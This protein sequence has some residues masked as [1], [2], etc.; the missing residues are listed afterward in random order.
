MSRARPATTGGAAVG[1]DGDQGE[2]QRQEGGENA[3]QEGQALSLGGST[4]VRVAGQRGGLHRQDREDA[5][6][7][8]EDQPAQEGEG[9]SQRQAERA[10]RRAAGFGGRAKARSA[11]RERTLGRGDLIRLAAHGQHP[12]HGGRG[13]RLLKGVAGRQRQGQAVG[14]ALDGLRLGVVD[15]RGVEGEEVGVRKVGALQRLASDRQGQHQPLLGEDARQTGRGR[16]IGQ[17]LGDRTAPLGIRLGQTL[18]DR[19]RQ[20]QLGVLGNADL[21]ADQERGLGLEGDDF[22]RLGVGRRGDR[23][24][25]HHLVLVAVVHQRPGRLA[26]RRRPDDVAGG[27]AARQGPGDPGGLAAV[28]GIAPVGVP[29]LVDLLAQGDVGGRARRDRLVARHQLGD[30]MAGVHRLGGGRQR[31]DEGE[32]RQE[33]R[34]KARHPV[35]PIR[36]VRYMARPSPRAK[37]R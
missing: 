14:A 24:R 8:V 4:L 20:G 13:L 30:Q 1:A 9:R 32:S 29:A 22:A 25:Q 5:R 36:Y 17:G 33:L 6:H 19:Q 11:G 35:I 16:R 12:G 34:K 28:A 7:Q 23:D 37:R 2:G 18:G 3:D 26:R 10:A 31:P 15:D 21:L 27:P